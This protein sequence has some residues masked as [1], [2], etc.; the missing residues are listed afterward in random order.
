MDERELREIAAIARRHRMTVAEWVRQ[1]LRSA[2]RREPLVDADRKRAAVRSAAVHEFP[3]GDVGAML[4][5]IERGYLG[6][7]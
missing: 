3:A 7:P 5:E 6:E 1:A 2:S 4:S